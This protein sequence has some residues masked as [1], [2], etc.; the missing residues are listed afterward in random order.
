[1]VVERSHQ[2][3]IY[4]RNLTTLSPR[5]FFFFFS[6]SFFACF[7]LLRYLGTVIFNPLPVKVECRCEKDAVDDAQLFSFL[8]RSEDDFE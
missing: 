7:D 5:F 1:M 4:A 3:Y 6:F 8:K 2:K